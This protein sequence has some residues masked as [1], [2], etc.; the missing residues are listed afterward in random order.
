MPLPDSGP[1]SLHVHSSLGNAVQSKPKQ[2]M[3]IRMT[4]ETLEALE[5]FPNHPEMH[6]DFGDNPGI[7][8]GEAFYPMRSQKESSPHE[9]YLRMSTAAK[10]NVPLKL[11]ANVIGKLMVERELGAKITDGVRQRTIEVK[12][13]H[14]ERQAILLDQ[15]PIPAPGSKPTKRKAPGSGTVVKKSVTPMD[16]LRASSS[17]I[18]TPRK[19][20]PLPQ[21][22]PSSRAN[23]DIR[24]RLVHC[25][26]MQQRLADDAIRM[27][28][29]A[30]ISAPAREDLLR[31]L[32]DVA[33]QT[34]PSK[35]GDKSPR[36]W[37]L[38]PQT[39]TEVRPYE[40]PKLTEAERTSMARQARLAFKALRIPES[41]PAWDNVRYRNTVPV[42]GAPSSIPPSVASSSRSSATTSSVSAPAQ[43][44]PKRPLMLKET[45]AKTKPD[46]SRMKGE[47]SMKDESAKVSTSRVAAVKKDKL[48]RLASS[49]SDSA[50]T[51]SVPTRRLPGSGYQA[52]KA[53]EIPGALADG[54]APKSADPR[55]ARYSL[56]ASL[57]SKPASPLPLSPSAPT[58]KTATVAPPKPTKRAEESDRERDQE[59]E[60]D[61]DREQRGRE[62]RRE[63]K[64]REREKEMF[65][66]ER[67]APTT[68]SKRKTA[69]LDPANAGDEDSF[70]KANPIP[71]K[72][73]I[74]EGLPL[75]VTSSSSKPRDLQLPKKPVQEANPSL[76]QKIKKEFS[77]SPPL[78]G[79][80]S[81]QD[82]LSSSPSQLLKAD[83]PK[84]NGTSSKTRRKS[85]IYTSSEDEGEIRRTEPQTRQRKPSPIPPVIDFKSNGKD[86][87]HRPRAS[88]PLPS[89]H[90]ALRAIYRSSYAN[91][92]GAFSKIVIQKQ[93]IEAI[94][95]GE[96]E[97]DV[98]LMD[99]DELTKLSLEHKA[100]KEE[101]EAI[102]E[103]YVKGKSSSSSE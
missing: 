69:N 26:A 2:A 36:P 25:L 80:V 42:I 51:K 86:F 102:Q 28:G 67:A 31:L 41:D 70:S 54:A 29:G 39:W 89:D 78:R 75:T 93:K 63:L 92:L 4:A 14:S 20:S 27:V 73:K 43:S 94:L 84:V 38:K 47:I 76:R 40:W 103:M 59:M 98:D 6:F 74:E 96:S 57:P 33:E 101:L 88:Y 85:P 23:V 81:G 99:P 9:I 60:R 77:S 87:R 1:L 44:E 97:S 21:N 17:S 61:R 24:R 91:Y 50:G 22:P 90:A 34:A 30:N 19:V 12:K 72:R 3:I 13:A 62:K 55:S 11:Y 56:P 79:S 53:L 32:E 16:Q 15:P 35:K 37:T 5:A 68:G 48:E 65:A 64:L 95:K 45:K 66:L 58:R 52:K 83:R 7:Y 8:I 49:S 100:L 46:A 82:R 10:P 18:A 71:K